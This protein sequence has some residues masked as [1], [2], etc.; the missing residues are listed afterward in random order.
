MEEISVTL[1]GKNAYQEYGCNVVCGLTMDVE[2]K[3]TQEQLDKALQLVE[4]RIGAAV[5]QNKLLN[6]KLCQ[7]SQQLEGEFFQ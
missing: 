6:Y 2:V 5:E 7:V 1:S 4:E 3:R